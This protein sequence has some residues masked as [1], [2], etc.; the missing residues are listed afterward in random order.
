MSKAKMI[1]T[2]LI[3]VI[4]LSAIVSASASAA[5]WMVNGTELKGS[6]ALANTAAVD[7]NSKLTAA[8]V[9]IECTGKTLNGAGPEIKAGNT[10]HAKSLE[11]TGCKST[12]ETCKLGGGNA[13]G[14]IGTLPV[15][16]EATLSGALGVVAKFTPETKLFATI[17]YEGSK[18]ALAGVQAIK[19]KV[20]V[21]APT[22]QDER[23][24]QEIVANVTEAS[25][26][27]QV[28][29]SAA[30]FTGSALLELSKGE[31]WSLL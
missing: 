18:C 2:T 25:D 19:G 9:T 3:A 24:A 23:T 15:N 20:T 14:I 22:G 6:A 5:G 1:V 28:G 27:L 16:A 11:F 26:E 21:T 10:G 8:E 29:S 17:D 4:G 12:T 30:E 7:K 13:T 31:K